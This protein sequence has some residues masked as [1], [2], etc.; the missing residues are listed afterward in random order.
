[1]HLLFT[2]TNREDRDPSP[3]CSK[4]TQMLKTCGT[5]VWKCCNLQTWEK[6]YELP[7]LPDPLFA[8]STFLETTCSQ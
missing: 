3:I 5:S 1:M 2:E 8:H 7:N 6:F 4:K